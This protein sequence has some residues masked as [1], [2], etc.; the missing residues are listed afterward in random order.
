VVRG[1]APWG[2]ARGRGG[3]GRKLSEAVGHAPGRVNLIG[4]HTDYNGGLVLPAAL[5]LGVRV[6]VEPAGALSVEGPQG[7]A[8]S[9]ELALAVCDELGVSAALR[10]QTEADLPAG[11]GLG[12]SAAFEVALARALR[13]LHALAL[14]DRELALA[15]HRAEN[16]L[17]RCG[18]M[19]QLCS[20][21]A[22]VHGAL[23]IDCATLATTEVALPGGI[24]FA[25]LDSQVRHDNAASGYEQRRAEC[26]E[27]ARLLGVELLCRDIPDGAPEIDD[28]PPPLPAR[29]M[30]VLYESAAVRV[31]VDAFEVDN[32]DGAALFMRGSHVSQRERFEVSTPEVD[33]L[34]ERAEAAGALAA[35]LTGGGF[36]GAVLAMC[37]A[38]EA[39][40]VAHAADVPLLATVA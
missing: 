23:M 5:E 6:R 38:G 35:R 34:V 24:E 19:D 17:V 28:L 22:P 31:V 10:I 37:N 12:S 15:C 32:V 2:A 16:R 3:G 26:E 29:V 18:V 8:R 7:D 30:H 11:A 1:A 27:A 14:D 13:S 21:L 39:R 36:G 25:V 4:E 9:H 40:E 33:A 20:A